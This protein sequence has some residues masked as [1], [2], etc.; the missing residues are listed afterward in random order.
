MD[1]KVYEDQVIIC[2]NNDLAEAAYD[3]VIGGE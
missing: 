2:A 3:A 1:R